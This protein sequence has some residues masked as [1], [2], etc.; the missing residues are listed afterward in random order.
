MPLVSSHLLLPS[1]TDYELIDSG[2]GMKFE[3]Y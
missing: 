3:R 2:D 1:Y